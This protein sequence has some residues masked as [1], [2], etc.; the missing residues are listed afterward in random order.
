[1][2]DVS[3]FIPCLVD[4]FLPEIGE[5]TFRVL[6]RLGLNPVYHREQTCCGMPAYHAG[7][8]EEA[9]RL[10]RHFIS[11]FEKDEAVVC[12]SGSCVLMVRR[13]YPVLLEAHPAWRRRADALAGRVHE[14]SEYIV[15][16]L[17]RDDVG[18][19]FAGK[20]AYHE[21]CQLSR[22][23]GV[24]E[25]PKRLIRASAGT[26]LTPLN[27]A[28]ECCGFGGDFSMKYP[29]ISEAMV[30]DKADNFIAGGADVLVMSEPGCLLNV[31]GYL[32]RHHPG[33]KAV[34]IACFLAGN[35]EAP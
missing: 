4:L 32:E 35:E 21:S 20:A 5:A 13:R 9:G 12:P 18:A 3:L 1:M 34:H 16:V 30:K 7:H 19:S 27:A 25:Q 29:E 6:R 2:K 15:D 10:A 23:L 33:R 11:I 17:G 28:D 22:G 8:L 24:I 14:L 31:R 26:E